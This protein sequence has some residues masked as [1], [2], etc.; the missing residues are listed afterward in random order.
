MKSEG[1]NPVQVSDW[2]YILLVANLQ[3]MEGYF[4]K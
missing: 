1:E 4:K 3:S 2:W